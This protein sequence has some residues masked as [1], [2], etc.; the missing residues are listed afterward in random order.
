V[1]HFLLVPVLTLVLLAASC[2]IGGWIGSTK[3]R[4]A[5]GT[6]LGVFGFIG[7]IIIALVPAR[8]VVPARST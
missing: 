1:S 8:S 5:M 2:G 7:W 3:D 4:T 6:V